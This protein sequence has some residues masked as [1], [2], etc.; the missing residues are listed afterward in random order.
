MVGKT[1]L[2]RRL[3]GW[4][5]LLLSCCTTGCGQSSANEV[6]PEEA[7]TTAGGA[8]VIVHCEP[9]IGPDVLREET[10]AWQKLQALVQKSNQHGVVLNLL[11]ARPWAEYALAEQARVDALVDWIKSGHQ[12]GF[13]HHDATHAAQPDFANCGVAEADWNPAWSPMPWAVVCGGN[14]DPNIGFQPLVELQERLWETLPKATSSD[15]VFGCHGT[16]AEM[17]NFEW[18]SSHIRFSQGSAANGFASSISGARALVG[19]GC[20]RYG[21]I[22]LPELGSHT[23][24]TVQ[25]SGTTAAEVATELNHPDATQDDFAVVTFHVDEYD[26]TGKKEIDALLEIVGELRAARRATEV[27]ENVVC[28]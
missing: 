26:Q 16:E 1:M 5:A 17:R 8:V 6:S 27:L 23:F 21:G 10:T 15:I 9:H 13:H 24:V 25:P 2:R 4:V 28:P 11:F 20:V 22:D 19:R 14:Y 3:A 18:Q 7:M 12:I